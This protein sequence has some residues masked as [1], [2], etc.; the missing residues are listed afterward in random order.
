MQTNE[1]IP[2]LLNEAIAGLNIKSGGIYVDM[3]LG[4]AGHSSEILKK[5]NNEGCL[6]SFDQDLEAIAY[7]ETKLQQIASNFKIINDNFRNIVKDLD[8]INISQVDGVIFDLGVSSP[9]FDEDYRGFSYRYDAKLDM[10]MSQNNKLTA[11]Y[12]VNNYS[13]ENLTKIF[14]EYGED[15]YSYNIAK[16]I[17]KR[18]LIKPIET[19]LDLVEIIKSSK[20]KK[21]LEKIGHPAKQ[22]FQ[23]LRIEVN[24]ELNA[25][26]E[27]LEGAIQK[28]NIGGRIVVI[29][30]HS[31]EDKIVKNI[32]KKY[33]V[34]EGNR[35][36]DYINP[37]NIK[38]PDYKEVNR[39]VITPSE[40]ELK[41]NRRSK[42]A[43]LRIL[44][45]IK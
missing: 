36:N 4:R 9:Q 24:D 37:K 6:I 12:I 42:S 28:L 39:K 23:A 32:F 14:K 25:L 10:R 5:L 11:E 16:N 34:I 31:L 40:E 3:T 33:S 29:T 38:T 41:I 27:A 18:R 15:K 30:F 45:K 26:K 20:P 21:E 35:L 19:T 7:S 44:E 13:L 43:K 1:H 2:V 8:Q 22:I 17:C